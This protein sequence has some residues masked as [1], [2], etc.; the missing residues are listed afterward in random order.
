MRSVMNHNF[1]EV[2]QVG[3]PRSTFRRD[4]AYKTTFDAGYLVPVFLEMDVL[5]GDT[6]DLSMAGFARLATPLFPTMDNMFMETFFFFCPYRI[7]WTNFPKMMGEQVD[8]GD[9]IDYTVP[10]VQINSTHPTSGSLGDYF[11]IPLAAGVASPYLSVNALPFRAYQ[12]IWNE[13]FRDQNLQD[14]LPNEKGD[15][16][17]SYT[18]YGYHVVRKR[19][20]RHDYFTSCLP[21]LQ[22]GDAVAL[23]LGTSAPVK[24]IGVMDQNFASG[25]TTA[26]EADGTSRTYTNLRNS[27]AGGIF[28]EGTAA[29][30]GYPTAYADLSGATAATINELREA[31]QVQRMLEKD[32]RAGTRYT[33][34]V[35]SHFQV[36]SPDARLQ[37]P[38]YLGG[39]STPIKQQAVART[40]SSPGELGSVGIAAFNRHGFVKSFT[41]H[42]V[43]IGLINVRADLTYQEGLERGWSRLD[44]YDFY[45]P[46]LA[47]LGEQPVY[48][49]EIYLDS[50]TVNGVGDDVFGYQEAWADYRYKK[51]QVTGLYR[52]AASGS[53]ESHHL[54]IEFG[55]TPTLDDTFIPDD[56]PIDRI[57]ATPTE[58]HF[59]L[60]S[61]FRYNHT[62]P[63]P[64]YSVPGLI[65]HF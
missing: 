17:H 43:V 51:S 14:S 41:E 38:E 28:I 57:I 36:T 8:P 6:I 59:E 24:G 60:D 26:Y 56:P 48:N 35:R 13:W 40:D 62:R 58:P 23:P 44:R 5:P 22:K 29:T 53:L 30:G 10:Q 47:H 32:A 45:W 54:A 16:P 61:F 55:S 9:S 4:H 52:S 21:F 27:G 12:L 25:P 11:G 20:K 65:D 50:T 18:A 34:I 33:E 31:F 3:I 63:M 15:G 1:S 7:L 2:P 19:N 64:T 49:K 42:G 46:S 39:G 37:R